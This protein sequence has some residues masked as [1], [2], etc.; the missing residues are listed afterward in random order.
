MGQDIQTLVDQVLTSHP[1]WTAGYHRK[2]RIHNTGVPGQ[3]GQPITGHTC[4]EQ[5]REANSGKAMKLH[6]HRLGGIR[7]L[8]ALCHPVKGKWRSK[9]DFQ[10]EFHLTTVTS[11]RLSLYSPSP[12]LVNFAAAIAD[13]F[14]LG[15]SCWKWSSPLDS[16]L[17]FPRW[18]LIMANR[19]MPDSVIL[20]LWLLSTGWG[21]YFSFTCFPSC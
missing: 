11:L 1:C 18:Q 17:I 16:F 6:T 9:L 15:I 14:N 21:T 4:D 7:T 3:R 13:C 19:Q 20:H 8:E 2:Q 12:V 5:L 10:I